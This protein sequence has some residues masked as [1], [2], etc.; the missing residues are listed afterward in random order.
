MYGCINN[1]QKSH[2]IQKSDTEDT[3]TICS[4]S[5]NIIAHQRIYNI[6]KKKRKMK[7]K[8]IEVRI[9]SNA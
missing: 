7:K 1:S 5:R 8:I 4:A 3:G 9:K 6:L 2:R